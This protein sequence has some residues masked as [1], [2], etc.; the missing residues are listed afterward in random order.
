MKI[1]L[2]GLA[3]IAGLATAAP[4]VGADPPIVARGLAIGTM[5]PTTVHA[6]AGAMILESIKVAPGGNFGWHTHGSPVAVV[7][8]AGT[9]T[10]FDPAIAKCAPFKV[11][12]GQ[13]FI[14]PAGHVHI[15]RNDGKTT[16]TVYAMYLG[17]PKQAGANVPATT[18]N[19]CNT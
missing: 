12:K 11:S 17:L 19:G 13:A 8:T 4:S 14:E 9:L 1:K 16:V 3:L 6:K 18:P 7:V 5:E 10:V 15:A 2:L